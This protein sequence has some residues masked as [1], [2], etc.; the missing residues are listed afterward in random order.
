METNSNDGSGKAPRT[1]VPLVCYDKLQAAVFELY[2]LD[3]TFDPNTPPPAY[4]TPAYFEELVFRSVTELHSYLHTMPAQQASELA[5]SYSRCVTYLSDHINMGKGSLDPSRWT[6]RIDLMYAVGERLIYLITMVQQYFGDNYLLQLKVPDAVFED[7]EEKTI[8]KQLE[9]L[10][11]YMKGRHLDQELVSL[12]LHPLKGMAYDFHNITLNWQQLRYNKDL[13]TQLLAFYKKEKFTN[14]S[15]LHLLMEN[16][17]N[18][19]SM[20]RL[21]KQEL[22]S[23]L[24]ARHTIAKKILFLRESLVRARLW[25]LPDYTGLHPDKPSVKEIIV[26]ALEELLS[27]QQIQEAEENRK[28]KSL[29]VKQNIHVTAW[30][31]RIWTEVML[32]NNVKFTDSTEAFAEIHLIKGY[33]ANIADRLYRLSYEMDDDS[34]DDVTDVI[35]ACRDFVEQEWAAIKAKKTLEAK[36]GA[37]K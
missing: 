36:K 34:Y 24:N 10:Q 28:K 6:D 13:M 18:S 29:P 20:I 16:N 33:T 5:Y 2:K 32:E 17:Y 12:V 37:K 25:Q 35:D 22:L 14:E 1:P 8:C 27:I 3:H 4:M 21:Y 23:Q 30:F 26:P 31:V 11:K 19:A 9:L 15:L 7:K